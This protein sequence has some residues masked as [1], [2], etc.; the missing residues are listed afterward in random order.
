MRTVPVDDLKGTSRQLE[1]GLVEGTVEFSQA[2]QRHTLGRF[3]TV[4]KVDSIAMYAVTC[5]KIVGVPKGQ[6]DFVEGLCPGQDPSMAQAL[7]GHEESVALKGEED[8]LSEV[9]LGHDDGMFERSFEGLPVHERFF[10]AA[11]FAFISRLGV[12]VRDVV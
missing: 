5:A 3:G 12:I 4:L 9:T 6:A 11:L 7:D 1:G 2:L 8:T 10:H